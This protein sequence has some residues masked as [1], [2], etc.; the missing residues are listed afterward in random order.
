MSDALHALF[1]PRCV[2]VIGASTD[3]YKFGGMPV[4]YSLE[5]GYKGRLCPVNA[6][7]TEVQGL[8]AFPD[9]DA[10][11][12]EV[13]C[14]VISVPKPAVMEAI[15]KCAAKGVRVA[16]VFSSS[17]AEAGA[18]GR[19]AQERM[20]DI[21]R[22]AGMRIL[23]PNCMGALCLDSGFYATFT[24]AFEHHDGKGVPPIGRVSIASQSGAIGTHIMV[25]LRERG[26]GMSK[27][28]TTG[29]QS[30]ID[31]A[32]CID[33][34]ADDPETGVIV[35][36]M[37]GCPDGTKLMR[38][39]EKARK[40]KKPVIVLKVGTTEIGAAAAASHTASL[41][42]SDS[43]VEA[44]LRQCGAWRARSLLEL[45]DLA[46][47]ADHGRF[48]E[49]PEVGLLT[50]SGGV[51]VLMADAATSLGLRVPPLP[52]S[53]QRKLLEIEPLASPRNPIDTS[54]IGMRDMVMN[55][56]FLEIALEDGGYPAAISF[57]T[58]LGMVER[59]YTVLRPELKRVR[60][61]FPDRLIV[62]VITASP[63]VR[64]GLEEDGF[65]VCEDPSRAVEWVA[66]MYKIREGFKK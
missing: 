16:A 48:P 18:E 53:A 44:A 19:R 52:K 33:Y 46:A 6:R 36:Y 20:V 62:L 45:T 5:L 66:A 23:G 35:T 4:H 14:A 10:I 47:A 7:A 57:L 25:L 27:W 51:G 29:N 26:I 40:A 12:G 17:F 1:H 37:E 41:A 49:R 63:E 38:A 22:E 61:R 55:V 3:R 13:D 2:A 31:I 39:L 54:A 15:E 60:A 30:D 64:R 8:P 34:F 50:I 42:G 11:D 43:V 28:V 24:T 59:H 58:H 65:L 21:A 9:I 56:R 32:D